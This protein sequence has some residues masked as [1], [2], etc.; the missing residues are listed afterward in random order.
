MFMCIGSFLLWDLA[1]KWSDDDNKTDDEK[2]AMYVFSYIGMAL[3][4]LY[5]CLLLVMRKRINLAIGIVKEAARGLAAMPILLVT[6]LFQAVGIVI[7]LVPWTIYVLYLASSGEVKTYSTTIGGSVTSY[8]QFEYTKNARYAFLY[9]L[10]CWFW[11]SEF[12]VAIG[13]IAVAGAFAGWYFT[14]EKSMAMNTKVFWVSI[15]L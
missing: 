6:P 5:I 8:H 4:A 2:R 3:T 10:F 1:N 12:I 7:F 15:M 11:T 14:R 13:Q 9:L